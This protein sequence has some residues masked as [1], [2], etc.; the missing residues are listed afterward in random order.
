M[1]DLWHTPAAMPP[2]GQTSNLVDPVS[3]AWEVSF[4]IGITLGPAIILVAMRVYARLGL[5][6]RLGIDDWLCVAS[7][8]VAIAFNSLVLSF[9]D[10]PGGG[11]IG[12]HMW[13]ISI[14]AE[15]R[16]ATSSIFESVLSRL[17]NTL[18]K[19][20]LLTLYLRIFN[21]IPRMKLLIWFG[22]V[23][24]TLFFFAAFIGTL[25]VC[26]G[27]SPSYRCSTMVTRTVTAGT[28]F[29]LIFDIYILLIPIY[30]VPSLKLTF[31]HKVGVGAV[32]LLGSFACAAGV[33]NV[34]IRFQ[35]FL[36]SDLNDFTWEVVQTYIT[37]VA[38][39]NIGIICSCIPVVS[40]IVIGPLGR[41]HSRVMEW[42]RPAVRTPQSNKGYVD[43]SEGS[44]ST[45][46]LTIP[47]GTITGLRSMIRN[48]SGSLKEDSTDSDSYPTLNY[49][50][51]ADDDYH[52]HLRTSS[53]V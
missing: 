26:V 25:V 37:K 40:A 24:V 21:P 12:R 15:L 3:I 34:A 4:T 22:L 13:D 17:A 44:P 36:T 2:E 35:I 28:V 14:G 10:I 1:D 9:L 42:L 20:S 18:A 30:L 32:F 38:E 27:D 52:H 16:Y 41:L 47:R 43:A 23:T 48:F 39:I 6:R 5:A 45:S 49:S 29:S 46:P 33:A 7:I 11:P 50:T 8:L 19:L 53:Q 31:R 51:S